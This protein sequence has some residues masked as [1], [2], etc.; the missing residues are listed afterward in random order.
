MIKNKDLVSIIMPAFNC[1]RYIEDSIKSVLEQS[2]SNWELLICDD[3]SN[4]NTLEICKRYQDKDER[5]KLVDN[6]FSKGAPGARNS[7]LEAAKGRYIAF[8]DA[9][10][11]WLDFKLESQLLYMQENNHVFIFSY[12]SVM[13]EKGSIYAHYLAP[14]R[15]GINLMKVSNFIPCS[16]VIYDSTVIG[17][18]FQ[19]N[20]SKRNDY[21]L[22][23]TIF[24]K[25]NVKYAYCMPR[26][27]SCYRVNSYGLSS[28]KS[29]ALKYFRHA[30]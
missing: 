7:C 27:T 14:S 26:I 8:L 12:N 15:V 11:I 28:N 10:D 21:A 23:L 29:D 4:D 9:D 19:P 1:E 30:L 17:K 25:N 3:D 5:I 2:Y 22:W 16:T 6:K 24:K 20:I 18:I 13:D